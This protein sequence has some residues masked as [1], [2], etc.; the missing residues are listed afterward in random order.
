MVGSLLMRVVVAG[1]R[2]RPVVDIAVRER[3]L[4][5]T[6]EKGVGGLRPGQDLDRD[7]GIGAVGRARLRAGM[8]AEGVGRE[9][10]PGVEAAIAAGRGPSLVT[11]AL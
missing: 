10:G 1:G 2:H 8:L 11:D 4:A 6:E 9:V 5:D 7:L 3:R